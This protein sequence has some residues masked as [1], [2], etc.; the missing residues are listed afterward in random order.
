MKRID[1]HPVSD[2]RFNDFGAA[3]AMPNGAPLAADGTFEYWSDVANYRIDGDT[4]IGYCTVYRQ[5]EDR[6]DWMEQHVK[7][8]EILIP[9]DGPFVLPVMNEKGDVA[10]FRAEPG[11]AVVIGQGV[12]HSACKPVDAEQAS[13]FVVFRRGTPQEDVTKKDIEPVVINRA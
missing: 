2:G 11:Q 8:P 1:Y 12:W 7:T 4:E 6:V 10:A 3:A 13:Y 9:I 5:E